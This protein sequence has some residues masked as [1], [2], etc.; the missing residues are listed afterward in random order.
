MH[1]HISCPTHHHTSHTSS[2]IPHAIIHFSQERDASKSDRLELFGKLVGLM[3]AML[4]A[5]PQLQKDL[6]DHAEMR[7]STRGSNTR[8]TRS[9]GHKLKVLARAHAMGHAG[10]PVGPTPD[11]HSDIDFVSVI[12]AK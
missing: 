6:V 12:S 11:T 1:T 8:K 2:R 9:F 7:R 10:A 4:Q 5:D 3:E